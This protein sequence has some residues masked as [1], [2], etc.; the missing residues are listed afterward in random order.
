MQVG[1]YLAGEITQVLY[2][3]PWVRCVSGNV[4]ISEVY[5]F[6][7][8]DS[9][10]PYSVGLWDGM[11]LPCMWDWLRNVVLIVPLLRTGNII[12]TNGPDHVVKFTFLRRFI[13]VFMRIHF[14]FAS[15]RKFCWL[16]A[17][18]EKTRECVFFA[19]HTFNI[20]FHF[21]LFESSLICIFLDA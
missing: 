12:K 5:L 7:I 19:R 18:L 20:H 15:E 11:E 9:W 14:V 8:F 3:I 10:H 21:L 1:F 4:Y 2:A 16:V 6:S 17:A 13:L